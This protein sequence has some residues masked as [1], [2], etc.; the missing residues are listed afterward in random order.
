M[1]KLSLWLKYGFLSAASVISLFPFLWMVLGATN[2]GN[3]V[4]KGRLMVGDQLA[5]NARA[6][7]VGT[8][9]G[10]SVLNSLLLVVVITV[11]S[12][13]FCSLAGYG[14]ELYQDKKKDLAMGVILISMMLPFVGMMIPLYTL[15]GRLNLLDNFWAI[16]L[17][18]ISSAF[19]IFFFRQ[20]TKS[21]PRELVQAARIDGVS[22]FGIFLRIYFPTMK[23]TY[24]AAAIITF[25]GAWNNYM[26][27]L[28]VLQSPD[29]QTL[30]LV[31]SAMGAS[32]VPDYGMLMFCLVIATVPAAVLFFGLQRYFVE[33]MVGSVKG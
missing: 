16:I 32:S 17:P 9:F 10:R 24:A 6:A 2:A 5:N 29:K 11:L 28:I 19:L 31:I 13:F 14:F 1:N 20:N 7:L 4:V 21:F 30:P 15:F 8:N 27:P 22:E 3:D 33:G 18:T 12:L 26:W 23:S 25:M